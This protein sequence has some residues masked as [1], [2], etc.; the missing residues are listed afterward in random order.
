MP[1]I[2]SQIAIR[3]SAVPWKVVIWPGW[4]RGESNSPAQKPKHF[5]GPI[6]TKQAKRVGST[7]HF[8]RSPQ[9]RTRGRA[10]LDCDEARRVDRANVQPLR[11]R[12]GERNRTGTRRI[13]R[14]SAWCRL[15]L[16]WHSTEK[17]R[18]IARFGG[19]GGR[20][21]NPPATAM[22]ARPVLKTGGATGP[23]PPPE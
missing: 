5:Q 8:V 20:E 1:T 18:R 22:A 16:E 4:R 21:S 11:D 14:A 23:L 13:E 7:W 6:A 9:F 3:R 2:P 19:G 12:C 10:A 15:A 17:P